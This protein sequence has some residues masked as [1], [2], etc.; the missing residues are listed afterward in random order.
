MVKIMFNLKRVHFSRDFQT[1]LLPASICH[2]CLCTVQYAGFSSPLKTPH[3][4]FRPFFRAICTL[5]PFS[6]FA[7]CGKCREDA[8]VTSKR[9]RSS[10]GRSTPPS[11]PF[12]ANLSLTGGNNL[13]QSHQAPFKSSNANLAQQFPLCVT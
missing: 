8:C 5:L 6:V 10:S 11:I 12:T 3:G 4:L 2:P 1:C 7:S 13:Q 9:D